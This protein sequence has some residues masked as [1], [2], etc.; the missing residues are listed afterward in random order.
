MSICL[1]KTIDA[2]P[3]EV[4]DRITDLHNAAERIEAITHL[5]VL[6]EGPIGA[7]TRFRETPRGPGCPVSR[8][9]R[10]RHCAQIS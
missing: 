3:A 9:R 10:R 6:T 1:S 7:G 5:E 2:E 8:S 4:F